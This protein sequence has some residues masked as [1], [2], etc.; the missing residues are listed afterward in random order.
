MKNRDSMEKSIEGIVRLLWSFRRSNGYTQKYVA[1]K[2]GVTYNYIC[3]VERG[4][5]IPSVDFLN[6]WAGIYNMKIY[7]QISA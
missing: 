1:E 5:R 2:L 4:H 6:K 3:L 7:L